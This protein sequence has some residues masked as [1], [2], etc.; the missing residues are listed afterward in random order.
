VEKRR[1]ARA[2]NDALAPSRAGARDGRTE[3]RR[4]RLLRELA[5]GCRGRGKRELKPIDVL[6]RVRELLELGEP[7]ASIRRACPPRKPIEVSEQI[8]ETI[9]RI[10]RAYGFPVEVYRFVG[11]DEEALRSAGLLSARR[12]RPPTPGLV[13]AG[14]SR[15]GRRGAA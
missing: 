2:F 5:E 6:T 14:L 13:G 15:T 9:R 12:S 7:L 11:L 10:H 8:L 4:Q 1:A 3:R